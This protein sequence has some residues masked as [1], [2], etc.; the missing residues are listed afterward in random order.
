MR[1]TRYLKIFSV[2]IAVC[3]LAAGM[4]RAEKLQLRVS[5]GN[6][7]QVGI[8][9]GSYGPYQM[10]PFA[11]TLNMFPAGS[12]NTWGHNGMG[13]FLALTIDSDGDG[14]PEDTTMS[15]DGRWT[16]GYRAE[17]ESADEL[18]AIFASGQNVGSISTDINHSRVWSSLDDDDL[19]DWPVGGRLDRDPNGEIVKHGAETLYLFQGDVLNGWGAGR[20]TPGA[21]NEISLYFLNYGESNDMVYVHNNFINVTEFMKYNPNDDFQAYGAAR[22]GGW[23]WSSVALYYQLR[24]FTWG[25]SYNPN[26]NLWGYHY[27]KDIRV[28]FNQNPQQQNW[29]PPEYPLFG[30]VPISFPEYN[31]ESMELTNFNSAGGSFG[32]SGSRQ[33]GLSGKSP[34]QVYRNIMGT[35]DFLPGVINPFTGTHQNVWPG[36]LNPGDSRYSQWIWGGGGA[37]ITDDCYG[38]LFNVKPREGFSFDY[39]MFFVYPD[40]IPFIPPQLDA[41]NI[42]APVIQ[43][44]LAP[45]ERYAE[46]ARSVAGGGY[47][48]PETPQP[49]T[50]TIIPNDRQVS[51][52]WSDVNLNTPDSYYYFLQ[53]AGL[54]PDGMY[55]EYDFEGY[56]VYRSLVGPN[57]THSELLVDFNRTDGTVQFHYI[58]RLEDD[59]PQY[60]MRN[61]MKIWYSVV[62]YDLNYDIATGES[63]SLPLPESAKTWNRTGESIYSVVPRSN[64]AEFIAADLEGEVQFIPFAGNPIDAAT[65]ELSGPG[66]GTFSDMPVYLAPAAEFEFVPV[67]NER[68]TQARSFRLAAVEGLNGYGDVG[69]NNWASIKFQVQEG[70]VEGGTSKAIIVRKRRGQSEASVVVDGPVDAEGVSYAVS[71]TFQNMSDGDFRRNAVATLNA[72]EYSGAPVI[73][74]GGRA[75]RFGGEAP[76]INTQIRAGRFTLTW[77][78]AGGGDLTLQVVDQTRGYTLPAVEHLDQ[79]YGWGFLTREMLGPNGFNQSWRDGTPYGLGYPYVYQLDGNYYFSH[80][81]VPPSQR[82]FK[83]LDRLPAANTEGFLIWVN[84]VNWKVTNGDGTIERMPTAGTTFTIDHAWG[85]WNS[86]R[87]VFTQTPDPPFNG[88]SWEFTI[89]PMTMDEDDID[90]TKVKVVPNPYVASSYLDL[91]PNN[92]RLEFT[93][94]PSR[95]TIRIYT[96]GGNL[97]NVLNHIGANRQ[98]WGNYTDWDRLTDNEP[99]EFSG[100]DNHGGTE[101]WNLRNRFGQTV[102]S[103]LYFYH[104]TDQ[105]GETHTGKFY[106]IN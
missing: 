92:R 90:L 27:E 8:R 17:P 3:G 62:P 14:V 71:A 59:F 18:A 28:I 53:E 87:T 48:L 83:L 1:Y 58:D 20:V 37:W 52:T 73:H 77:Q 33:L 25:N 19:I 6:N 103:G 68:L 23:N 61:G 22:P 76:D 44:A 35:E 93:N 105:R 67:N 10:H 100:Y 104:V 49:P 80:A 41:A 50:L 7:F 63:F 29:N 13:L 21:I 15:T 74:Y 106:V 34:G 95:C 46:V 24:Y 32:V 89:K 65:Y 96:L 81:Y 43:Q 85:S 38:E 9:S 86:D 55:R 91:S 64:A 39:A 66:D 101:P 51:I 47:V 11:Q 57:D 31:G 79:Q 4:L 5:Q 69:M 70:S 97:V 36:K 42:D 40:V 88:D 72:G 102:A 26:S 30:Y 99:R 45:A 98:G 84:G 56:K 82:E 16:T 54:D 75:S 2:L 78:D 94:L 12:G 60:R